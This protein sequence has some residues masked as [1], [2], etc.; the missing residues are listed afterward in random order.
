MVTC[1]LSGTGNILAA[2]A[3]SSCLAVM[4]MGAA[5]RSEEIRRLVDAAPVAAPELAADILIR[6]AESPRVA[7]PGWKLELLDQAFHMAGGSK[8]ETALDAALGAATDTD[9]DSG[10]RIVALRAHLDAL[11]LRCRALTATLSLNH[12]KALEL[13][14]EIPT[15]R[16]PQHQCEDATTEAPR[17][18]FETLALLVEQAFTAEERAKGKHIDFAEEYLRGLT[19]PTQLVPAIRMVVA[20]KVR[21]DDF[22]RLAGALVG[23]MQ[24][25]NSD[26]RTF[27]AVTGVELVSEVAT[28]AAECRQHQYSLQAPIAGFRAYLVRHFEAPRCA[29]SGD[30]GNRSTIRLVDSFNKT[31][32]PLA[33]EGAVSPVTSDEMKPVSVGARAA[34]YLFWSKPASRRLMADYKHLRFG[35][36]EQQAANKL[37]ARRSDGMAQFL[38]VEQRSTPEW[39]AAAQ[40]Y[41]TEL[42]EWKKDNDEPAE[43]YFHE[44]CFLYHGLLDI[45]PGGS[46]RE[47]VLNSYIDFL[48]NSEV[49]RN[50]PPEWYMQVSRLMKGSTDASSDEV[51]HIQNEMRARGDPVMILLVD[52][53]R[54]K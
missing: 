40:E 9:S 49:E 19:S 18:F 10:V 37:K 7:E 36:E 6:I 43:S 33:G 28:F 29:E 52:A 12:K 54:L 48:K 25:M 42:E 35:T 22:A 3:L 24:Q 34:V 15:A 26:D 4:S 38:T 14:R 13:F 44:V 51:A 53:Q 50:S 17:T 8:Y 39:Q 32:L 5:A 20:L 27:S 23:S 47:H 21:R 16:F 46:L 1:W 30:Q 11:S 31:L 2:A 41:L 45:V